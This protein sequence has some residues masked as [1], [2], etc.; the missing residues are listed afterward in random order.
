MI[1][2]GTFLARFWRGGYS[3]PFSWWVVGLLVNLAAFGLLAAIRE[4]VQHQPFNPYVI[5]LALVAIWATLLVVQSFQSV[6][7]WRS[8]AR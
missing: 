4:L 7:V 8:A 5:M 3:L 1:F 2:V 6:G